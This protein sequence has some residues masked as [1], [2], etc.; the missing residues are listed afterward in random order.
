MGKILERLLVVRIFA[1]LIS[2]NQT[3]EGCST[4]GMG[5]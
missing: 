5:T 3:D 1:V 2:K 4:N